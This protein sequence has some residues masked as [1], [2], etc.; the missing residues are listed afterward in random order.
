[1]TSGCLIS[2]FLEDATRVQFHLRTLQSNTQEKK[3]QKKENVAAWERATGKTMALFGALIFET[4]MGLHIQTQDPHLHTRGPTLREQPKLSAVNY[5]RKEL[6]PRSLS[7]IYDILISYILIS[8][9]KYL[10]QTKNM[11]P[12]I[13]SSQD[14]ITM[15]I[16]NISCRFPVNLPSSEEN[17]TS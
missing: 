6:H 11:V 14:T 9:L 5:C 10:E 1:M 3:T 2:F 12:F 7:D 4:M 15:K 17:V 13:H 16:N 8:Y